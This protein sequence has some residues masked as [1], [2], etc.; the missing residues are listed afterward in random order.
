MKKEEKQIRVCDECGKPFFWT[1]AFVGCEWYCPS[2]GFKG[3]IFSGKDVKA[4][5]KLLK[6]RKSLAIKWGQIESHLFMGGERIK[7]C[8]KCSEE[9]H[10]RHLTKKETRKMKW[11]RK[12]LKENR[13]K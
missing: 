3:D 1:F 12:R 11:A 5:P 2:C 13:A 8:K 10:I 4:T 9:Y 6:E 7:G